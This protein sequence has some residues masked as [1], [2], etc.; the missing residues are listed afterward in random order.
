MRVKILITIILCWG[1]SP[2]LSSPGN[3]KA[4]LE[5]H[6]TGIRSDKG[7]IAIGMN[8]SEEGWP[9]E[10]HLDYNW[11]KGE[12]KG[13]VFKA[14]IADLAYGT[15][16]ISVLDDENGNLEMDMF[17]GIPKEGW[18]FSMNPP[19]KLTAPAFNEC[20]FSVDSPYQQIT[21]DLRYVKKGR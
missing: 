14:K 7:M 4:T 2:L 18:G 1:L 17:M 10:P 5:I 21:I 11:V 20:S 3:S 13:G 16:A 9:R 8:R 6:F 19:F 12:L 15:Y